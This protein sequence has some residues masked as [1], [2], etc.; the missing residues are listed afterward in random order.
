MS[1]QSATHTSANVQSKGSNEL[2]GMLAEYESAS[3]L[4]HACEKV[5]DAGYKKW[6]SHSPFPVHGIDKAMGLKSSNLPWIV[7]GMAVIG[8]SGG[9]LL[10]AW[11]NVDAYPLVIS[12]KP[13]LSWP[14]FIPVTFELA[15][16]LGAFGAV[17]G[18]LGLNKLPQLY[19]ALFESSRFARATDDKF[20]ISIEASDPQFAPHATKALLEKS[21]AVHIEEVRGE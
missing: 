3:A 1:S 16:L 5:R 18:M 15:V 14:A 13:Y 19:H 20:F 21:G 4:F 6:D 12:A 10:Q 9:F 2:F 7:A 17:F 8:G 11:I